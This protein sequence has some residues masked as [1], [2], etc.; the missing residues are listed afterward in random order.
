MRWQHR[1]TLTLATITVISLMAG[2]D[3]LPGKPIAADQLT[4]PAQVTDFNQLYSANCAACHG[5]DGQ[6][7]VARP[8]NDPL[9]LAVVSDETLRQVTAQGV[10]GTS[11]P[12]FAESAGGNLTDQQIDALIAAMRS[13]WAKPQMFA[14]VA[15][16]PYSVQTAIANGVAAG[17]AQ[18]GAMVYQANCAQCHGANGGGSKV[19]GSVVDSDFLALISDQALRTTV[20]AGRPDLGMPAWQDNATGQPIQSQAISDVVAWITSH[21]RAPVAAQR[22]PASN[23]SPSEVKQASVR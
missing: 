2:C 6:I 7:G 10:Q 18:R 16:P 20:I 13:Q 22:D 14:N 11:M 9:Y 12:A 3:R 8:L 15:L 5:A 23:P 4:P 17:D 21:R 1:A 19:A